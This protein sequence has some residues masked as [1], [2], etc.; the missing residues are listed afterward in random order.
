MD[1]R[2]MGEAADPEVG[3]FKH[4]YVKSSEAAAK[5]MP[6]RQAAAA[7][8]S[9]SSSSQAAKAPEPDVKRPKR[10]ISMEPRGKYEGKGEEYGRPPTEGEC[11][12]FGA[13]QHFVVHGSH[14]A[15]PEFEHDWTDTDDLDIWRFLTNKRYDIMREALLKGFPVQFKSSGRSLEPLVWSDDI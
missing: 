10:S 7:N 5:A 6:K 8:E 11:T 9:S 12:I 4:T 15:P 14:I 13:K 3:S 2:M 1:E